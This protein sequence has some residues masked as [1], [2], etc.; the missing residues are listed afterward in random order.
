L[1]DAQRATIIAKI[2]SYAG[3]QYILSASSDQE[4]LRFVRQIDSLLAAAGWRKH[5][6]PTG[7][8]TDGE[9]GISVATEPG[10]RVQVALSRK[11][12]DGLS[13]KARALADALK[14]EGV[15]AVPTLVGDLETSPECIQVRVG[16]KP[17]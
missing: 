5:A 13:S 15:A 3:Q 7:I 6:N 10:V 14:E 1:S 8:K 16:S 12:D 9:V 4:S 11:D 2:S 17:K